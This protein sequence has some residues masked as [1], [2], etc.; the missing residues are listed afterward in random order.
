MCRRYELN[1]KCLSVGS[2]STVDAKTGTKITPKIAKLHDIQDVLSRILDVYQDTPTGMGM[3]FQ[4]RARSRP[5][6][7]V[8][9]FQRSAGGSHLK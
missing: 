2:Q 7:L 4:V 8:Q 6:H 9:N 1:F 5:L 3:R